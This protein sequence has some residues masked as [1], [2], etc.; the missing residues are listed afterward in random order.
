MP[1]SS[2]LNVYRNLTLTF[3]VW[4]QNHRFYGKEDCDGFLL[5]KGGEVKILTDDKWHVK[6]KLGKILNFGK[7]SGSTMWMPLSGKHMPP[8]TRQGQSVEFI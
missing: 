2:L 6:G 4:F 1:H 8:Q 3:F 7:G 5:K